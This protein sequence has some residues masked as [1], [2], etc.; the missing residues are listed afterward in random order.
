MYEIDMEL[1]RGSIIIDFPWPTY[2]HYEDYVKEEFNATVIYRHYT[3]QGPFEPV[4][5]ISKIQFE[6]EQD[7]SMFILKYLY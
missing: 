7:M 1:N 3:D 5:I 2:S 4:T 6:T